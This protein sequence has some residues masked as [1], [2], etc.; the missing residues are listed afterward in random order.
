MLGYIYGEGA[1]SGY[2]FSMMIQRSDVLD[3]TLERGVEFGLKAASP[4]GNLIGQV[5]FGW[6]SDIVGRKRM[7]KSGRPICFI[8][9]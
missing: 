2:T 3:N 6:L 5:L 8:R 9:Y 4:V 7:C 1:W